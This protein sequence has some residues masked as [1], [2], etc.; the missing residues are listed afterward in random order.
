LEKEAPPGYG[1][2]D[3]N[4]VVEYLHPS[5]YFT[6]AARIKPDV[7]PVDDALMPLIEAFG[8]ACLQVPK[9]KSAE[10]STFV[11]LRSF[12]PRKR[13]NPPEYRWIAP[14][15]GVWYFSPQASLESHKNKKYPIV[16]FPISYEHISPRR[17]FWKI[18]GWTL[19][20]SLRS[21]IGRIGREEHGM[22]LVEEFIEDT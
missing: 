13:D 15:W 16:D 5:F 17:V 7:T 8:Q 22:D 2:A 12:E 10:L 19:Y 3:D 1:H 4:K 11:P 20:D 21:L 6:G 9:L 14:V 18:K